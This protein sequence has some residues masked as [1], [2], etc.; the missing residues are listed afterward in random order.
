MKYVRML[1]AAGALIGVGLIAWPGVGQAH[2]LWGDCNEWGSQQ[3][4]S[5][6]TG[7]G[8][9]GPVA[10]SLPAGGASAPWPAGVTK[11]EGKFAT[12]EYGKVKKPYDCTTTTTAEATTTTAAETTTTAAETTTTVADT[13]TTVPEETTTTVAETTTT[14]G[15]GTTTTAAPTTTVAAPTTTAAGPTPVAIQVCR[16]GQMIT[17]WAHERLKSD[18]DQCQSLPATGSNDRQ[19]AGVALLT[20]SAGTGMVL[21]AR[22]RKAA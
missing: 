16:D 10:V 22:R 2:S 1:V 19:M 4:D 5:A 18:S 3:G 8:T 7:A 21:A 15:Q 14:V 6:F 9:P 17:I 13:T 11:I 12:G 20:V